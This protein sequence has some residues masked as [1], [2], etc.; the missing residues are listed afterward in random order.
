MAS[1]YSPCR[2]LFTM[3]LA[4]ENCLIPY[5]ISKNEEFNMWFDK[6]LAHFPAHL[7]TQINDGFYALRF[8][9]KSI[10]YLYLIFLPF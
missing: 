8:A 10:W 7:D 4:L 1:F 9:R 3:T 2:I 5:K 6:A